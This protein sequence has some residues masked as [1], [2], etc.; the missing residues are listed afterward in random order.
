[1]IY[2]NLVQFVTADNELHAGVPLSKRLHPFSN[3][4]ITSEESNV[5]E[6]HY[7]QRYGQTY[8]FAVKLWTSIP[9]G[10]TPTSTKRPSI[11]IPFGRASALRI[12]LTV[13][14]KCLA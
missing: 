8:L 3:F 6:R 1:M 9:I 5:V 2:L 7:R 12:R 4:G 11:W 10:K 14:L 13:C